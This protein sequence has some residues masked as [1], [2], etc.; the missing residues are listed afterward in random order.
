MDFI[1][2][3]QQKLFDQYQQTPKC[4]YSAVNFK[5]GEAEQS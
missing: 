2:N 1:T 3:V 5:G 4:F